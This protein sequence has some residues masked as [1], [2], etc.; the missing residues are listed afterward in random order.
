MRDEDAEAA[1]TVHFNAAHR[2]AAAYYSS[3]V[4]KAWAPPVD[5]R[6]I[7]KFRRN[8]HNEWRIVAEIQGRIV[9]YCTLEPQL[10]ELRSCYVCP[11]VGAR[12]V[13]RTL[14]HKLEDE[15]RKYNLRSLRL[16]SSLAARGFYEKMGYS[17]VI[18]KTMPHMH[19]IR[20]N[21][22]MKCVYMRKILV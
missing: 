19:E 20:P 16:D 18:T 15:A 9:G 7:V 5:E 2:T 13:G 8:F 21:V 17:I 14:V 6:E 1:L 12:G 22:F 10:G 4:L 11:D 3:L